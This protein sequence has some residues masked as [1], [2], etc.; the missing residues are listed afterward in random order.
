[1]RLRSVARIGRNGIAFLK[2]P[3]KR[4]P[5]GGGVGY[6]GRTMTTESAHVGGEQGE[7][8]VRRKAP[9]AA[10]KLARQLAQ[11][12]GK[13][14]RARVPASRDKLAREID[15]LTA[16][17]EQAKARANRKPV[18]MPSP[19]MGVSD[20]CKTALM[21]GAVVPA[22]VALT[23]EQ[24]RAV[25]AASNLG[26]AFPIEVL[27]AAEAVLNPPKPKLAEA[28]VRAQTRVGGGQPQ[29]HAG[30]PAGAGINLHPSQNGPEW[31]I[32]VGDSAAAIP[33]GLVGRDDRGMPVNNGTVGDPHLVR[34]GNNPV[35]RILS[36]LTY[37]NDKEGQVVAMIAANMAPSVDMNDPD[38]TMFP[39][40]Q[41]R[42][43]LEH[44]KEYVLA[45]RPDAPKTRLDPK[46]TLKGPIETQGAPA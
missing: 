29:L 36:Q 34:Q 46:Y 26:I 25:I 18:T 17:L 10:E 5:F 40:L 41:E 35:T 3:H 12:Q 39:P 16:R 38:G 19:A 8:L 22:H 24:A 4:L 21:S 14:S 13:W 11:V 31:H 33:R 15:D 30:P 2:I 23:I 32:A 6:L 28:M 42:A 27:N 44:M 43:V 45:L 7:V 1:M 37:P 20:V 9:S